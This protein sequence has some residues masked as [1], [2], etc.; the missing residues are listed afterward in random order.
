M[1]GRVRGPKRWP[2]RLQEL[3]LARLRLIGWWVF[4]VVVSLAL[5]AWV[6]EL[7]APWA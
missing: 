1:A 2:P 5:I 4:W 7:R 6:L 3:D